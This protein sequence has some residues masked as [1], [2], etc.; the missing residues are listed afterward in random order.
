ML[1]NAEQLPGS[2]R[3]GVLDLFL[4]PA[5]AT[6]L[7]ALPRGNQQLQLQ[8]ASFMNVV[9]HLAQ[10][11][12]SL[13]QRSTYELWMKQIRYWSTCSSNP[14]LQLESALCL[15]TLSSHPRGRRCMSESSET[16]TA[17]YE[18]AQHLHEGIQQ[19]GQQY[20][21]R[22]HKEEEK[23]ETLQSQ[24]PRQRQTRTSLTKSDVGEIIRMQNH[25]SRAFRN[26]CTNFQNSDI[27]IESTFANASSLLHSKRNLP[28]SRV[29]R[30]TLDLNDLPVIGAEEYE[31]STEFGWI[32]ILTSWTGSPHREVRLNAIDSLVH[33]A[34]QT[35]EATSDRD[36]SQ[37]SG[38]D[39]GAQDHILQA[40]LTSML[41]HI[42]HLY[43]GD[44]IMAVKQVEEIAKLSDELTPGNEKVMFNP[45]VVDA[46]AAA[47]AVLAEKHHE[48]LIQQGV[49]PLMALLGT[50]SSSSEECDLKTQCS[51]VI[52]NL[53][54][55]SCAELSAHYEAHIPM[56]LLSTKDRRDRRTAWKEFVADHY[57]VQN[58]LRQTPSGKKFLRELQ[59]WGRFEDPMRRS[60]Y[61]RVVKNMEAYRDFVDNGRLE[62]DIYCEGVHPIVS[63]LG[64]DDDN[65]TGTRMDE[66]SD[67]TTNAGQH[68]ESESD[69]NGA[70][71]IDVVFVHGLRGHP[72]GTWR[73]DMGNSL[74]GKND[75]WPDI[76]L[77]KDLQRHRVNARL[78]T[79]GYEAG[80]VSWSSPWPSL[81]LQERGKVMLNA[82]HAANIGKSK[83]PDRQANPVVFVTHSMGGILVKK[84]LLLAEEQAQRTA[85]QSSLV[86]PP[87]TPSSLR[88]L[89]DDNLAA[90][91]KR[92]VFLAVPHFG[93]DLAKGVRSESV[94]K[95]IKT[96]P[97]IQ[98]LCADHDGRLED[99][100]DAFKDLGIDCM[101]IGEARAAPLGFG[102]SAMVVKPESADPGVGSFQILTGSDHMTICKAKRDDEPHYQAILQYI[103]ECACDC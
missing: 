75:I 24:N 68:A 101:S 29:F 93:S 56:L 45:A 25:I 53:V 37:S 81:T 67:A 90:N 47:L 2:L 62:K 82:L 40:W 63:F 4:G 74:D 55:S 72:F 32:D 48:E 44:E 35:Q 84:M 103:L 69:G 14:S 80:M 21:P 88:K 73:T 100:N 33:L 65:G 12:A 10:P 60:S 66:W 54:A 23:V 97:A 98:D 18:F 85:Q 34:E 92:V 9:L 1:R 87:L 19:Q 11:N 51:R 83:S 3:P 58:M 41:Q 16:M 27:A 17:L 61:F 50:S 15:R 91:T 46:G 31:S 13:A 89:H 26:I 8:A 57:D 36:S 71:S 77:A 28:M 59:Q 78:V 30:G 38:G 96:H 39:H 94:R 7:I 52:A 49:I 6:R 79:L 76:L 95:L 20:E 42:R 5:C 22:V 102:I 86:L 70:P 43:G 99:L 64:E